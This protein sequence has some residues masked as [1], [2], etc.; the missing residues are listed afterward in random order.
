MTGTEKTKSN[1]SLSIV[2]PWSI[3]ES[4]LSRRGTKRRESVI[5]YTFYGKVRGKGEELRIETVVS[6][7]REIPLRIT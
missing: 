1:F 4:G 7:E 6:R 5:L 3:K 2:V